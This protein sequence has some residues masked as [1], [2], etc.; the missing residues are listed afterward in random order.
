MAIYFSPSISASCLF[1]IML[2]WCENKGLS[3][4][5]FSNIFTNANGVII[6][7]IITINTKM[8]VL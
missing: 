6:I 8:L 5:A 4:S 3:Y 1:Q 2:A 7:I